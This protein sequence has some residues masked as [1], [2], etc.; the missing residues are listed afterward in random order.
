MVAL[1][2]HSRLDDQY[3]ETPYVRCKRGSLH[4][5]CLRYILGHN[6]ELPLLQNL[7]TLTDN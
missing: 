6:L 4:L 1:N 5:F 2:R 7:Q 3:R